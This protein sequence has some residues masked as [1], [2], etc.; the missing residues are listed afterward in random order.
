MSISY[1]NAQSKCVAND[2]IAFISMN[3]YSKSFH[4]I[5]ITV[6]QL[7]N[8]GQLW[9]IGL[10]LD[11]FPALHPYVI[12]RILTYQSG[13]FSVIFTQKSQFH[14]LFTYKM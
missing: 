11:S 12:I 6:L 13:S 4:I 14:Y 1:N 2:M 10:C 9:H 5:N 8:V 7:G 3:S